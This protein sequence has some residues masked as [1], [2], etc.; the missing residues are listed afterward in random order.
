M[1]GHRC[2]CY[3]PMVFSFHT[4]FNT[5]FSTNL[6]HQVEYLLSRETYKTSLEL[7]N[8]AYR[9]LTCLQTHMQT[10]C[11]FEPGTKY[12]TCM[13]QLFQV[14]YLTWICKRSVCPNLVQKYYA[15]I[16]SSKLSNLDMQTFCVSKLGTKV[17]CNNYFK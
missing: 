16:I 15:T 8:I 6:T 7:I 2:Y 9:Y 12:N 10:F 5:N 3:V 13:R 1:D 11:V 14:N 17:L 4:T